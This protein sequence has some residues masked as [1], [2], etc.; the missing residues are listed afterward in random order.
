MI[1]FNDMFLFSKV[2]E[3]NGIS[4]AAKALGMVH[5]RVS[6]RIKMLETS[7]GVQLIQ[8]S[9][10]HFVVTE[11]GKKF[12]AHC[13]NMIAE[14]S[15]AI[16]TIEEAQEKP[17]GLVRIACPSM[18][19]Q[20]VI[21]PLLPGY[22]RKHPEVRIAVE[23]TEKEANQTEYFDLSIR[24][25]LLPNED[26]RLVVRSLGLF[27]PVM[28]ASPQLFEL[29]E[30]PKSIEALLQLPALTYS[31]PQGPHVWTLVGPDKNH[32]QVHPEPVLMVDDFVVLRQAAL[33]GTGVAQ[34]P[35]ALCHADIREGTLELVLPEF[36]APVAELQALFPSRRGMLPAVRSIIDF[37]GS[38]CTGDLEHSQIAQHLN[39]GRYGTTRFWSSRQSLGDMIDQPLQGTAPANT[40]GDGGTH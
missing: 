6:R 4:G 2:V 28:V 19:A 25:G 11:L 1:D 26:S 7:L 24:I 32:L 9:T 29:V 18:L 22:L 15:A 36:S 40:P 35:L 27:Q 39:Q 20:F 31:S 13:L 14:A 34:L 37:L 30:R 8:R 3:H 10:R 5:S 21:G 17:S 16:E 33:Q 12:N 38:H 23:T